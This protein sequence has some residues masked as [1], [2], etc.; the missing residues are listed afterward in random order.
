MRQE[1]PCCTAPVD[2]RGEKCPRCA[3]CEWKTSAWA[4]APGCLARN[5]VT[6]ARAAKRER[7]RAMWRDVAIRGQERGTFTLPSKPVTLEESNTKNPTTEGDR[8]MAEKTAP[9]TTAAA[10]K[11][12]T[13]KA[14]PKATPAPAAPAKT[15]TVAELAAEIGMK[16]TSLRAYLRR[17][18]LKAP[19]IEVPAGADGK[20]GFGPKSKYGW[21]DGSQELEDLKVKIAAMRV[22]AAENA[23]K[24]IKKPKAETEAPAEEA[25][26]EE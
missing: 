18:G 24:F 23:K 14:A 3:Q 7:V 22:T 4:R 20:P 25:S 1:C 2:R 9:K 11:P 6:G 19:A 15:I 21:T 12:A 26:D 5:R 8:Q 17:A 16:P 10:Q 13:A